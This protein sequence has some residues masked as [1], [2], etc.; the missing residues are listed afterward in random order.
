MGILNKI[1]NLFKQ[2]TPQTPI[3]STLTDLPSILETRKN[4]ILNTESNPLNKINSSISSLISQI[5]GQIPQLESLDLIKT[6]SEERLRSI[7]KENLSNYLSHLKTL[8]QSLSSLETKD[9]NS[10]ISQTKSIFEEFETKSSTS[11]RKADFLAGDALNKTHH[12][13]ANFTREFKILQELNAPTLNTLQ[14]ISTINTKLN[15]LD[16]LNSQKKSLSN[17]ISS[18]NKEISNLDNKNSL[19]NK[20]I[21]QTK[22]S[23]EFLQVEEDK[24]QHENSIS[25]LE[26][27]FYSLK[28]KIDFKELSKKYHEIEKKAN[29]INSHKENFQQEILND[30]GESLLQLLTEADLITPEI[31][32]EFQFLIDKNLELSQ[33]KFQDFP[34]KD[35]ESKITKNLSEIK[36]LK[37]QISRH[38]KKL[39]K[40]QSS[41][42]TTLS[43][44]QD[45]LSLLNI[46]L[47]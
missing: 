15:S 28:S 22:S 27:Q 6:Q 19:L 14:S 18:I 33:V 38:Q 5:D 36:N 10:L 13:L 9:L 45:E 47:S 17:K 24:K 25:E 42:Q 2:E 11:Y 3:V 34:I 37:S 44:L 41:H 26:K 21:E 29:T 46:T 31:N 40:L 12:S 30:K 23:P 16:S 43:S 7:L 39:D 35:L 20:Q 1:K 8:K 32:S 4:Q